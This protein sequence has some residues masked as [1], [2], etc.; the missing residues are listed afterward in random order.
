[1]AVRD[2]PGVP[3]RAAAWSV[4]RPVPLA[5]VRRPAQGEAQCAVAVEVVR[6][7]PVG[8]RQELRPVPA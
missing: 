2:A 5:R 6:P 1:L 7:R 8:E 4:L 3:L